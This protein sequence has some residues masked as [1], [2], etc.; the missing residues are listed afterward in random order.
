MTEKLILAFDAHTSVVRP[1]LPRVG[2]PFDRSSKC[3]DVVK[4]H[5]EHAKEGVKDVE[6]AGHHRL[7]R[8]KRRRVRSLHFSAVED[9]AAV[10]GGDDA[11]KGVDLEQV[12]G[13]SVEKKAADRK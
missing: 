13:L 8:H 2:Q 3:A 11:A 9:A 6:V 7:L 5:L 12:P 1:C 4:G 10:D